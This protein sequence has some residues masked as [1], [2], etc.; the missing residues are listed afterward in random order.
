MKR[1]GSAPPGRPS[2]PLEQAIYLV[3]PL[4]QTNEGGP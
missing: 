1:A 3:E 2:K 4:A